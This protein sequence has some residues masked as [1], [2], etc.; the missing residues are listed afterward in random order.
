MILCDNEDCYRKLKCYRFMARQ[1]AGYETVTF[2]D[3]EN[4]FLPVFK[5][6]RLSKCRKC[7]EI[8]C[9]CQQTTSKLE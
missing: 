2:D 3:T 1:E 5:T 9:V 8:K 6:D 4:C 7:G